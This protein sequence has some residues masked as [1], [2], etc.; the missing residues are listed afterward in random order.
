MAESKAGAADTIFDFTRGDKINL[1]RI[2]AD[3]NAAN[4]NSKFAWLGA[5]AF[6]GVAGQL[7][8]TQDPQYSRAWLVEADI[9]GDKVADLTIYLVAPADFLPEKS[10]FYV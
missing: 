2:D 3:G 7:R 4:G 5:D 6:T 1:A 10:D 8:V 9:D